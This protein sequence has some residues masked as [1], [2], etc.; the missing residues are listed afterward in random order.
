LRSELNEIIKCFLLFPAMG[1]SAN[2][3]NTSKPGSAGN[4]PLVNGQVAAAILSTTNSAKKPP[5]GKALQVQGFQKGVNGK[6][7]N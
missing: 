6:R 3:L 1:G 2:G 7:L 5:R 4:K